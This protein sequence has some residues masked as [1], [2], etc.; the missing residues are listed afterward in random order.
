MTQISNLS[1]T[2]I[3]ALSSLDSTTA[4]RLVSGRERLSAPVDQLSDIEFHRELRARHPA[5]PRRAN[6]ENVF[7]QTFGTLVRAERAL[8]RAG[9][10]RSRLSPSQRSRIV[11]KVA[12]LSRAVAGWRA[13]VA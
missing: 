5:K 10:I 8:Y 3:C 9:G 7:R 1:L 4:A 13:T 12:H 2:K 6:R 11:E